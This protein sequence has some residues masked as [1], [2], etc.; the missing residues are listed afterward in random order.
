M[1]TSESKALKISLFIRNSHNSVLDIFQKF[2]LSTTQILLLMSESGV[3]IVP[4]GF[5]ELLLNKHK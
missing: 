3:S 5:Q 1:I 2:L 4:S